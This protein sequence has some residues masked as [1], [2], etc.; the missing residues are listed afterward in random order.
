LEDEN[1]AEGDERSKDDPRTGAESSKA[2]FVVVDGMR[3]APEKRGLE[4]RESGS[5]R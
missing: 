2:S 4:S 1:S 5:H 3:L